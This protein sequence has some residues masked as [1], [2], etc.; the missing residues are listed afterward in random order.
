M[1]PTLL[2]ITRLARYLGWNRPSGLLGETW[3]RFGV[4]QWLCS[5]LILLIIPQAGYARAASQHPIDQ[6]RIAQG[7]LQ[8]L[9][10]DT[11]LSF[12]NI[13]YAKPPL[14]RL[15]WQP[16]QAPAA[17]SGVFDATRFGNICPQRTGDKTVIGNEACLNLNVA[18]PLNIKQDQRLPVLVYLHGGGF[19]GGSGQLPTSA[20]KKFVDSDILLVSFNYRL[21]ALGFFAHPLLEENKGANFGLQDM[22]MALAWIKANISA[23]GGDP[24]RVTI[25]GNS[26]G[27]MAVQLLMVTPEAKGLFSGAIAQSPYGTWPKP[28]TKRVQPLQTS[29]SAE[30]LALAIVRNTSLSQIEKPILKQLFKL[31]AEQWVRAVNGFHLPLVDGITLPE[32]TGV[33]FSL[34]KQHPVPYMSGGTSF[35]GSVFPHSGISSAEIWNIVGTH[36]KQIDQLFKPCLEQSEFQGVSRLFGDMRYLHAA[37]YLNRQM[38]RVNQP[39]YLY[40]F[41]YVPEEKYGQRPGAPHG[42]DF[43]TLFFEPASLGKTL[44]QYWLNFIK[45]GDPNGSDMPIWDSVAQEGGAWMVFSDRPHMAPIGRQAE[46][47]LLNTIYLDRVGSLIH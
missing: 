18:S 22:V 43:L 36:K 28:R 6:V 47:E 15:R 46:L 25:M 29:P 8:G 12:R 11:V 3:C 10:E 34:G 14:G 16:P 24:S 9:V 4:K 42:S 23:F 32:E 26:A 31:P 37:V 39:S 38:R 1:L 21:G 7:V 2:C 5:L 13:P 41:D 17:F 33:L 20:V 30:A 45:T 40:F 44:R 35:E 27:G 19:I